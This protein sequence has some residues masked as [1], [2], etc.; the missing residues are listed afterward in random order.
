[1][2]PQFCRVV[3]PN[4]TVSADHRVSEQ[5][6]RLLSCQL[7]VKVMGRILETEARR[8][9]VWENV[10]LTLSCSAGVWHPWMLFTVLC[11]VL[12]IPEV[13][14]L[15]SQP[16]NSEFQREACFPGTPAPG[17]TY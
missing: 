14:D 6:P 11:P 7:R 8:P 15:D 16:C 12:W 4:P 2:W 9:R 13:G 10:I 3:F 17:P 1:M 5:P